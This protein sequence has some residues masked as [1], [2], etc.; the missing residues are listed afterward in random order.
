MSWSTEHWNNELYMQWAGLRMLEV[1]DGRSRLEL[2]IVVDD[3][4][5]LTARTLRP[6]RLP[7][8]RGS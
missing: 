6:E 4:G 7:A 2:T 8:G 1:Q 3:S 5:A